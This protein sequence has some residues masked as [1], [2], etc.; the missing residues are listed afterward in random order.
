VPTHLFRAFAFGTEAAKPQ[1]DLSRRVHLT[2]SVM[3][4]TP[5]TLV[6]VTRGPFRGYLG[7]ILDPAKD[8]D[9]HAN[10]LPAPSPGYF[11]VMVNIS[12]ERFAAHMSAGELEAVT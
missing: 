8:T 1:S 2:I 3:V 11:W 5:G 4:F 12:G 10:P 6:K 7:T 9:Q